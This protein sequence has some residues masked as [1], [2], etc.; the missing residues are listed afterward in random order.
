MASCNKRRFGLDIEIWHPYSHPKG[1][2][3]SWNYLEALATKKV[4][5]LLLQCCPPLCLQD[6]DSN[7]RVLNR[8]SFPLPLGESGDKY[9]WVNSNN[10]SQYQCQAW[11]QGIAIPSENTALERNQPGKSPLASVHCGQVIP[12]FKH[13]DKK[14][15]SSFQTP[16]LKEKKRSFVAEGTVQGTALSCARKIQPTH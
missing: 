16:F 4:F 3:I 1:L 14:K 13:R 6:F 2:I 10:L 15:K 8:K 12:K 11:Q 9:P 7:P 5:L